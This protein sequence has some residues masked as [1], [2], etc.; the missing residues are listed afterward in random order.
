MQTQLV[1]RRI[2]AQ[3]DRKGAHPVLSGVGLFERCLRYL[4]SRLEQAVVDQSRRGVGDDVPGLDL[5]SLRGDHSLHPAFFDQDLFDLGVVRHLA[6]QFP[7]AGFEGHGEFVRAQPRDVGAGRQKEVQHRRVHREIQPARGRTQ[8]GPLRMENLA[9]LL[10]NPQ[11]IRHLIHGVGA[12]L[13]KVGILLSQ[14]AA[15]W[16]ALRLAEIGE[17]L[18]HLLAQLDVATHRFPAAGHHS[19]QGV[20]K[21]LRPV[22]HHHVQVL[23]RSGQDQPEGL[24]HFDPIQVY[25]Q[26][27]FQKLPGASFGRRRADVGKLVQGRLE[28]EPAAY[29]T[30]GKA[31]GH[32]VL[33][34]QQ[35]VGALGRQLGRCAQAAVAGADHDTVIPLSERL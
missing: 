3:K 5:V 8:V 25:A 21:V 35:H 32:R 22:R 1:R 18:A 24:R 20:D 14:D 16:I 17:G 12:G 30:G 15:I 29:E 6:A 2:Q 11:G 23:A 19:F 10:G 13:E 31:A 9:C 7:E 27:I 34:Q 33:F 28:F 26:F 4:L